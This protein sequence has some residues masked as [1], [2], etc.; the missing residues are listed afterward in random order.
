[1]NILEKIIEHKRNEVE[2][3]KK[4]MPAEHL[5]RSPFLKRPV[6]SL[7]SS[8][9]DKRLS[10]IIA[11]FKRASPSKGEINTEIAIEPVV[12]GYAKYGAAGIS[13]LTE[14]NFFKGSIED[15]CRARAAAPEVSLLR[16]DFIID[17]YQILEAKAIGA[18]VILLIA[19]CLS[20]EQTL[21]LAKFA[22][23]LNLE[24]LLEIHEESELEN[25]NQYIDIAGINNR[26]LK[27]FTVDIENS[28]KLAAA[29]PENIV[30][31]AESGISNPETIV[32][33]KTAGFSGFLIGENFMKDSNPV[34]AFYNFSHTLSMLNKS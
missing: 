10:G 6:I 12:S 1:M 4:Q 31:I 8:L 21:E 24:V 18:D 30:K 33:L 23:S 2:E 27:D 14:T 5:K 17:E 9:L 15:F 25:F 16:K 7:K 19:A 34:E 22:K 13:V 28:K 32:D 20:K 29:L 11:E 3:A 26:N